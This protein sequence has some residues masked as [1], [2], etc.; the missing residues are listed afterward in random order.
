MSETKAALARIAC[1][2]PQK[3]LTN[4]DLVWEFGS[5]TAEK[6][7]AKTGI[8]ERRVAATEPVSELVSL[9]AERLFIEGGVDRREVDMLLLCTETPDYIMPPR[10]ASSMNGW[11]FAGTAAPSTTTSA[12][13]ATS[14]ACTWPRPWSGPPLPG[15]SCFSR[16]MS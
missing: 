1:H 13:R 4:G 11:A 15:R 6:I 7:R 5:W 10:P 8:D 3:R 16:A 2:L 9:A 14:T 12:V